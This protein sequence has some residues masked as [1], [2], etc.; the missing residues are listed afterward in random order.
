MVPLEVDSLRQERLTDSWEDSGTDCLVSDEIINNF[1]R[2]AS[3]D[4]P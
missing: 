4:A 2:V 3:A 1:K